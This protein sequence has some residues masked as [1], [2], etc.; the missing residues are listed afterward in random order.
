MLLKAGMYNDR[1]KSRYHNMLHMNSFHSLSLLNIPN[2][3]QKQGV[4]VKHLLNY[5]VG[6]ICIQ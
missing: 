6:F 3:K 5:T 2:L 4:S 1:Y